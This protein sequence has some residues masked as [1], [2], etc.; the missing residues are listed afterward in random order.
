M[1]A[2][3][4][5]DPSSFQELGYEPIRVSTIMLSPNKGEISRLGRDLSERRH[6]S[7]AF[8]SP[9]SIELIKSDEAL[10]VLSRMRLYAVGP[11]TKDS[12]AKLGLFNVKVP[13]EYTSKA[14]T[15]E[16]ISEHSKSPFSSIALIRS[17]LADN[18][19]L[20]EL[21]RNGIPV[22]EYRIYSPV[23]DMRGV[24]KFIGELKLGVDLVV[25]TSRSSFE[26]MWESLT[27]G[28]RREVRSLL[29]RSR[30]VALGPETAR[31]LKYLEIDP[32]VPSNH[33]IPGVLSLLR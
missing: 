32:S 7:A 13:P 6:D 23:V 8:L 15:E 4:P 5:I 25:F 24:E 31:S 17:G 27:P 29:K 30:V 1:T 12:L 26:L 10:A 18:S 33:S 22:D 16:I 2:L 9:R 20:S 28:L 11:S 3:S 21:V 14:L 19:M